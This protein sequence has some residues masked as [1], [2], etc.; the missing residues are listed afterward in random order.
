MDG[1][2]RSGVYAHG[3]GGGAKHEENRGDHQ[4]DLAS[5]NPYKPSFY[6]LH[7]AST[8]RQRQRKMRAL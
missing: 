8:P 6:Y 3:L 7:M 4:N 1:M 5:G 2:C